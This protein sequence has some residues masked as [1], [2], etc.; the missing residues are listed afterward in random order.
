MG[1]GSEQAKKQGFRDRGLVVAGIGR[2]PS[3]SGCTR[4]PEFGFCTH[5]IA[6]LFIALLTELTK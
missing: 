6:T 3:R 4:G 1:L 2:R 5:A